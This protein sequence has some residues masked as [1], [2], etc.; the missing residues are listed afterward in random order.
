MDGFVI[1]SNLSKGRTTLVKVQR[2]ETMRHVDRIV[3]EVRNAD[4]RAAQN[5]YARILD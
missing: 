4:L 2:L 1:Y 3:E 5:Y